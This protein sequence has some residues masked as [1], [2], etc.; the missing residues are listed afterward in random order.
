MINC[1]IPQKIP[2]KYTW[3]CLAQKKLTL[4]DLNGLLKSAK[5]ILKKCTIFL[6]YTLQ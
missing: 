1:M 2:Q 5:N 6:K 3:A 4:E